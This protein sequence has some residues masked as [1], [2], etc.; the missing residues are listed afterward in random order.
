MMRVLILLLGVAA[1]FAAPSQT[2][3]HG[4]QTFAD[5]IAL[6]QNGH[7]SES[8][9]KNTSAMS[10]MKACAQKCFSAA[11]ITPNQCLATAKSDAKTYFAGLKSQMQADKAAFLTCIQKQ[12]CS[13]SPKPFNHSSQHEHS[14]SASPRAYNASSPRDQKR[15]AQGLL[16]EASKPKTTMSSSVKATLHTCLA[17]CRPAGAAE[18]QSSSSS[19]SSQKHGG[20]HGGR[21]GGRKHR[22]CLER[23]CAKSDFEAC[24]SSASESLRQQI[25]AHEMSEFATT[26]TCLGGSNC[27]LSDSACNTLFQNEETKMAAMKAK[28]AAK[29]SSS[30]SS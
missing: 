19:Q 27:E 17:A 18:E 16:M 26:C 1:C 7:S 11:G 8:S 23:F 24:K 2:S 4:P 21:K 15:C 9:S 14:S 20:H 30:S 25:Q 29:Q 28:W 22:S 10:E 6:E 3:G 12:Q 13:S 5:C